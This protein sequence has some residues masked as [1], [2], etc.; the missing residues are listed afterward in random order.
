MLRGVACVRQVALIPALLD[1]VELSGGQ[2]VVSGALG[3]EAQAEVLELVRPLHNRLLQLCYAT[4]VS[5]FSPPRRPRS[6]S[7]EFRFLK[8]AP[9][10]ANAQ[11]V[12]ASTCA[13]VLAQALRLGKLVQRFTALD[14]AAYSA[15]LERMS[16]GDPTA[17]A[18]QPPSASA[19]TS[20]P[21]P[22]ALGG[23]KRAAAAAPRR[24]LP[25][26][27]AVAGEG[28]KQLF[29][30]PLVEKELEQSK[31]FRRSWLK[32]KREEV[33]E[34]FNGDEQ[35]K[36][37]ASEL[38]VRETACGGA[39][40]AWCVWC[41]ALVGRPCSECRR[42]AAAQKELLEALEL[43][44]ER[45]DS[46]MVAQLD[47]VWAWRM[48]TMCCEA[49]ERRRGASLVVTFGVRLF[50]SSAC[51]AHLARP[52][53]RARPCCRAATCAGVGEP[54]ALDAADRRPDRPGDRGGAHQLRPR[55]LRPRLRPRGACPCGR[56]PKAPF[57]PSP[58]PAPHGCAARPLSWSVAATHTGHKCDALLPTLLA[59]THAPPQDLVSVASAL[60]GYEV[61]PSEPWVRAYMAAL[62]RALDQGAVAQTLPSAAAAYELAY[63]LSYWTASSASRMAS[64]GGVLAALAGG[65]GEPFPVSERLAAVLLATVEAT[66]ADLA[67]QAAR[68]SEFTGDARVAALAAAQRLELSKFVGETVGL[69]CMLS[70]KQ[71]GRGL[72]LPDSWLSA[73]L[74]GAVL[75]VLA[76]EAAGCPL[77]QR[78]RAARGAAA[79][80]S[81]REEVEQDTL[82]VMAERMEEAQQGGDPDFS[83]VVVLAVLEGLVAAERGHLLKDKEVADR[84]ME[85]V[86]AACCGTID[87]GKVVRVSPSPAATRWEGG[88]T[89]VRCGGQGG[90]ESGATLRCVRPARALPRCCLRCPSSRR[91][92]PRPGWR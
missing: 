88:R 87:M 40:G 90:D 33:E 68:A 30:M 74:S 3:W 18:P 15:L 73:R 2:P 27:K 10:R 63:A 19:T 24:P 66:E 38:V 16:S 56:A 21:R 69:L 79:T 22:Q 86:M 43:D 81:S 65:K 75:P 12:D 54:A 70:A 85:V 76:E 80:A 11:G 89:R 9:T 41:L 28:A 36:V 35:A 1:Q 55:R 71:G 44:E 4:Q 37:G 25:L 53:N 8:A 60:A 29:V 42:I 64:P 39:C 92:R 84:V 31:A 7:R 49:L 67:G 17:A 91:G 77:V 6:S 61:V 34:G 82:Q 32:T 72:V 23:S 47:N 26:G 5:I 20:A 48:V 52:G 13:L 78:W 50:S 14:P 46:M 62:H 58:A 59:S 51:A 83:L 57:L 45:V